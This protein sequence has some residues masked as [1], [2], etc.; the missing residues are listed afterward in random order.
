V[1]TT[2]LHSLEFEVPKKVTNIKKIGDKTP[3]IFG[4]YWKFIV[5]KPRGVGSVLA[6]FHAKN[7]SLQKKVRN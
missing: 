5:E 4:A 1:D 3:N 6:D 2:N 7:A